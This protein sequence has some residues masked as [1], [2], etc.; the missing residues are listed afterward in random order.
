MSYIPPRT[1]THG[2]F[3]FFPRGKYDYEFMDYTIRVL[4]K[5][6]E[7]GFRVY[8]DPHQ[9]IVSVPI[10]VFERVVR[11]HLVGMTWGGGTRDKGGA[12]TLPPRATRRNS[13]VI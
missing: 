9:D 5:I 4:R 6:K 3:L 11:F 13:V 7:Y 1:R 8:M 12:L 10:H 2:P